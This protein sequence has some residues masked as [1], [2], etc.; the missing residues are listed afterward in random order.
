MNGTLGAIRFPLDDSAISTTLRVVGDPALELMGTIF[1]SAILSELQASW[2]A[3]GRDGYAVADFIPL[4]PRP[5]LTL[6]ANLQFPFLAVWRERSTIQQRTLR[7]SHKVTDWTI[8]YTPGELSLLE[9][10]QLSGLFNIVSAVI[11][12]CIDHSFISDGYAYVDQLG[13]T[14][15]R[16]T[17]EEQGVWSLIDNDETDAIRYPVLTL[18]LQT[19]ENMLDTADNTEPFESA[20]WNVNSTDDGGQFDL[21]DFDHHE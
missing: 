17:G 12:T 14:S 13:F 3:L 5:H 7:I 19:T 16:I 10:I 1:K 6:Q 4:D 11:N 18:T 21:V 20:V 8:Q 2:E 9:E 15:A